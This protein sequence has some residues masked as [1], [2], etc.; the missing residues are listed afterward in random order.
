VTSSFAYSTRAVRVVFG[1]GSFASL[2][3]ELERLGKG[4]AVIL[5]TPGRTGLVR[6]LRTRLDA[7]VVG[8]FEQARVHVPAELVGEALKLVRLV[9]AD[10]MVTLG[11]GSAI[12]LAKAVA[13]E[14]GI[15]IL[16]VPTTY[17]GSEMTA[18][19]G[20]SE[21]ETKKTGRDERVAPAVVLYDPVLTLTLSPRMSALSGL[22]A[23]AHAVEA[24]YA[25]DASPF[26]TLLASEAIRLL[27]R[28]LPSIH[29][30]PDDI[31]ARSEALLG[32][33]FAGKALDLTSM[34]LHHKLAHALGGLGLPHALT[35]AVLLPHVVAFNASAAS[36]T[37]GLVA[38]IL[39]AP[40]ASSGVRSLA[41]RLGIA[42]RLRDAGL[43]RED[44]PRVAERVGRGDFPNP[45]QVS[46][47]NVKDVLEAAF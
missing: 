4:R 9:S 36:D 43:K 16:A 3:D 20:V 40:E 8:T 7:K 35:H 44:V 47:A 22:N 38:R 2:P 41:L 26:S 37:M 42:D 25:P 29:D 14:T 24:L 13:R 6:A 10:L 32:A 12:G 46:V 33:H 5:A 39:D 34:G 45:R 28:A 27:G 19:W 18:I 11:G 30:H 1:S 23:M 17:S 21:E 15:T 31:D